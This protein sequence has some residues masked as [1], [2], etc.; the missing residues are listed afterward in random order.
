MYAVYMILYLCC[1]G[2]FVGG[3]MIYYTIRLCSATPQAIKLYNISNGESINSIKYH[4]GFMGQKIGP[5]KSL[6]FHPYKVM[7]FNRGV[8]F[9]PLFSYGWQQVELMV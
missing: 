9:N 6:S 1:H 7:Y 5:T 4:D 8:Y 3:A 2:E